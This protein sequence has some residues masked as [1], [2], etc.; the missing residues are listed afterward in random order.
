MKKKSVSLR[1]LVEKN[2]EQIAQLFRIESKQNGEY[3]KMMEEKN[4]LSEQIKT[5]HNEML[6]FHN[7]QTSQVAQ[8]VDLYD[9]SSKV[10]KG[11]YFIASWFI[12]IGGA[13]GIIYAYYRYLKN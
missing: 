9:T 1:L 13:G 5:L 8:I 7:L 6:N 3:V 4:D 12:K 10:L 2:N 11:T